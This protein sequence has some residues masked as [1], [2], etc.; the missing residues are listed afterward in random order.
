MRSTGRSA[1][2]LALVLALAGIGV[3]GSSPRAAQA[4]AADPVRELAERLLSTPFGA[5][6]GQTPS[7]QLLPDQLPSDL[8]LTIL[9]PAGT[10]VVGSMVRSAGGKTTTEEIVLDVPG[11]AASLNS[12]YEQDLAAKGWK[13]PANGLNQQHGFVSTPPAS[14]RTF[15][16]SASGP[17]LNF[18]AFGKTSGPNDVRLTI[19]SNPGPC[20]GPPAPPQ[21]PRPSNTAANLLPALSPPAGVGIVQN[22]GGGSNNRWTS[23]ATATTDQTPGALE[24]HFAQQ[25]QTAGWKRLA[26]RDDGPLSWSSWKLPGAGDWQGLLYVV[27]SPGQ[28]RRSLFVRVDS[29]AANGPGAVGISYASG[30]T[31]QAVAVPAAPPPAVTAHVA[32][33]PAAS[34]PS[35]PVSRPPSAAP[36]G[37]S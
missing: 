8:P 7:V 31:A 28:N 2:T 16:Q 36:S 34:P 27:Q 9:Q 3:A 23:E 5:P 29:T 19:N 30:G 13:P 14:N 25:L 35:Q 22:G 11:D 32:V 33:P 26:G 17:W 24:G 6:S 12:A 37:K 18:S 20:A 4:Q 21:P 15:C 1:T 10:R